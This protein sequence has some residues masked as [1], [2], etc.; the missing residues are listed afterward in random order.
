MSSIF[1]TY[2]SF[3][4]NCDADIMKEEMS[5]LSSN[6][7]FLDVN[8]IDY[9]EM[10]AYRLVSAYLERYGLNCTFASGSNAGKNIVATLIH[11][12]SYMRF[13]VRES[14]INAMVDAMHDSTKFPAMSFSNNSTIYDG[15]LR[16]EVSEDRKEEILK[17]GAEMFVFGFVVSD[18]SAVW[19]LRTR[20]L[21]TLNTAQAAIYTSIGLDWLNTVVAD[22]YRSGLS[23]AEW[24]CT[25]DGCFVDV[26]N[27]ISEGV[28]AIPCG[29]DASSLICISAIYIG[30]YF[31]IS[32]DIF[33]MLYQH[34]LLRTVKFAQRK[35]SVISIDKATGRHGE[36]KDRII[37][38][39]VFYDDGDEKL[40]SD[41]V[42]SVFCY[43]EIFTH[44]LRMAV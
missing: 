3:F 7:D 16:F 4:N 28:I 5:K 39:P 41:L 30:E 36:I 24:C 27:Q 12:Y 22:I 29:N 8:I 25:I 19:K 17:H 14:D 43:H 21:T 20:Y 23:V 35:V 2:N 42:S 37:T 11:N 44:D 40:L 32:G 10:C 6:A 26:N 15:V 9:K 31:I 13:N 18:Y 34:N 1:E 33:T 38:V